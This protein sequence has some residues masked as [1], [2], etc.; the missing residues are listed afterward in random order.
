M[1]EEVLQ[2]LARGIGLQ[3]LVDFY[4]DEMNAKEFEQWLEKERERR[5]TK[6]DLIEI[7]I[8]ANDSEGELSTV[9]NSAL[10]EPC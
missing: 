2:A 4:A 3:K 1:T 6:D 10:L 7:M 8:N 5:M 9:L